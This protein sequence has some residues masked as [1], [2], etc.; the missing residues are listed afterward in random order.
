MKEI[1]REGIKRMIDGGIGGGGGGSGIDMSA[2]AGLASQSWVEGS[3]VSKAF[4]NELFEIKTKVETIV[5]DSGGEIISD[6]TIDGPDL[7]P[8]TLPSETS[9]TDETTGNVTTVKTTI[10]SIKA[11]RG[12]WTDFFLSALGKNASGTGCVLSLNDLVDVELSSP[13]NGQALVYNGTSGKWENATIQSSGGT[14]TSITAGTGLSGGTIT[15]SGTI[16][17]DSTYLTY[18]AHGEA[19]YNNLGNYAQLRSP[20]DLI[21]SS[22]EFTFA[23]NQYQGEI[24]IN[25][26]T[27]GGDTNGAITG[28][29]L[30]NG[31]GG[32]LGYFSNGQYNG[33]AASSTKL[34]T[35]RS[36]WGNS[37]D[38]SAD[39]NGLI[40]ATNGVAIPTA[41]YL[42]I[43]NAYLTYDAQ[44][45]AIRV[46]AN[47]DGTG[48]ASFYAIGG[49][50]ALGYGPGGGGGGASALTDLVDV[51]ISSPSNG[52]SL[53][54]DS[55]TQ[56]WV[57]AMASL[58]ENN[59]FRKIANTRDINFSDDN[60]KNG[61]IYINSGLDGG[62]TTGFWYPY[63]SVLNVNSQAASWQIGADSNG[64]L[65]YRSLWWSGGGGSWSDWH[66]I[67]FTSDLS[68]YLPLAGGTMTGAITMSQTSSNRR[69]GIIG[70]YD[71]NRAAAIW[72]IGS[73]YQIAAD[74]LSFGDLY[75]AA[76]AYF[77]SGYTFGSGYSESHSF[78]WC[79]GGSVTAA[80][81][82]YVWSRD[83]FIKYGSSDSYVLLG[84]GGHKL[85]SS[86]SAG[87][88]ARLLTNDTSQNADACFNYDAGLHFFRYNGDD[89]AT[90]GDGF[91]LQWVWGSGSV[92][93]Q[94]FLD[95]NPNGT[96]MIRGR[97]LDTSY[98]S[99]WKVYT[100]AYHPSADYATT[101]GS[102]GYAT[103]AGSAPAS[104]VYAWAKA[105]SKPDYAFS[106]LTSHPTTLSGYGISAD[107]SLFASVSVNYATTAGSAPASDVYSWAKQSTKPSYAFSEL[108][109]HP[110]TLSGYGITD[111]VNSSTT[112]WG[113]SISNGA[114]TGSLSSVADITMSGD[115]YMTGGKHIYFKSGNSY[116]N[117]F[118]FDGTQVAVGYGFRTTNDLQLHG[119]NVVLL[120][121]GVE[122]ARVTSSGLQIGDAVL[123]Y[124]SVNNALKVIKS[125]GTAINFYATGGVSALGLTTGSVGSLTNL[126]VTNELT[127]QNSIYLN[128]P[129]GGT[130]IYTNEVD[131]TISTNSSAWIK[132]DTMCSLYGPS[133]WKIDSEE[134][135]C[136]F[137]R[138]YLD[139][140]SY[141]YVSNGTL[142]YYNGSTSKQVAFTN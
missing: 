27:A 85:E 95:D 26:R 115:L 104:D 96:M 68:S 64:L 32:S 79:Q 59:L 75:G 84:G 111:A 7:A 121:N 123:V 53:V 94:L 47:A 65:K 82:N 31:A 92:G 58:D 93:Q 97:N 2:L 12:L 3:Y 18:I 50:S 108:T 57:N 34:A 43:G 5:K 39:V 60:N 81:G 19:A 116:L 101:A 46:S 16:A 48:A 125:D 86:L 45:N 80:L 118:E 133:Y 21:H 20:N 110:T 78:V 8:N 138:Y 112:W 113:Q 52:Q 76:Y 69:V 9:S 91:I 14:V 141:L 49:V 127:V 98:T 28:Y 87:F 30:G 119:Q 135:Y 117:A 105:A 33:N 132:M 89:T 77:G 66:Q 102:A 61:I 55:T 71:P 1:S 107:D 137:K 73:D 38:G 63:G 24:W 124:E 136:T 139:S 70:T 54:Y 130:T 122:K 62:D 126:T 36:L 142:Y 106:E 29:Y 44:N 51:E 134:G 42:K 56:K 100:D 6:T 23:S 37:F 74:G 67:A 15:T 129:N 114:V 11:K 41:S 99:W 40:S 83:G 140:T 109:T 90:G 4:W 103:T 13:S 88:A 128:N 72:T 131:L 35:A 17:I 22:N 120:A 10:A 25:Y